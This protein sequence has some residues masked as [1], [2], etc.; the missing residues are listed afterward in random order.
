MCEKTSKTIATLTKA[1]REQLQAEKLC[2][3]EEINLAKEK[4]GTI[5]KSAEKQKASSAIKNKLEAFV[6]K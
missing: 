5:N 3:V 1:L 4:N 2:F 6:L